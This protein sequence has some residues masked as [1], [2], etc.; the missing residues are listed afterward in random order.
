MTMNKEQ[1]VCIHKQ[2]FEFWDIYSPIDSEL[3][4]KMLQ[5]IPFIRWPDDVPC[6]EANLYLLTL[7]STHRPETQKT[8]AYNISHLL[9]YCFSNQMNITD[10]NDANFE[11][12]IRGLQAQ[13][14]IKNERTREND[15]VIKIG[16]ACIDFLKFIS[17]M[18]SLK[19]FIGEEDFNAIQIIEKKYSRPVEGRKKPII[20]YYWSHDSFP[21]PDEKKKRHPIAN[22][23]VKAIKEYVNGQADSD[24][25]TRDF[26]LIQTF[27]QTG[28]R[29]V[30]IAGLKV[31]DVQEALNNSIGLTKSMLKLPTAK[32]RDDITERYMPVPRILIDNLM[33]YIRWVR[34]RII[35]NTIGKA[36]DH[37]NVFIAHTT[38]NAIDVDYLTTLISTWRKNIGIKEQCH[39]HLF[40]HAFVTNKFID[41]IYEHDFENKDEFRKVLFNTER[42]KMQI[43]EWTGHTNLY[44]LDTYLD[45]AFASVSGA[46]VTYD[47]VMLKSSVDAYIDTLNMLDIRKKE[48]R[49]SEAEYQKEMI[50]LTTEFKES[51]SSRE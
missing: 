41:L 10:L 49:I 16:R 1:L 14:N 21:K 29:R 51:R 9:R 17:T 44:S 3:K 6:V 15:Q 46:D 30:E 19:H 8:Y 12:F 45:L 27:E 4:T 5:G 25:V 31:E 20:N 50:R 34:R 36:H 11:L 40:R 38:G 23:T 7:S 48:K 33:N 42:F 39:W 13:R 37:G 24:I 35:R 47:S 26:C 43:K 32:R 2:A 22:N 28:A 18:H